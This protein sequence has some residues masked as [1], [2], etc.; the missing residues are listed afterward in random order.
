[1]RQDEVALRVIGDEL[2]HLGQVALVEVHHHARR[3]L[4]CVLGFDGLDRRRLRGPAGRRSLR[5]DGPL[6]RDRRPVGRRRRR[7]AAGGA[8][9]GAD[10]G[11]GVGGG[12]GVGRG[13]GGGEGLE[14]SGRTGLEGGNDARLRGRRG[15]VGRRAVHGA[16]REDVLVL[17]EVPDVVA[18]RGLC[19]L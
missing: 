19:R 10:G 6:R 11:A 16:L 14:R 5:R 17:G 1:L 13:G 8:R 9:G 15:K 18:C 4:G 12:V 7:L 3:S 2:D